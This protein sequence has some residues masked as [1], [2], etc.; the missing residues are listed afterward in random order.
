M[1]AHET[2]I[3][4]ALLIGMAVL[5]ALIVFFIITTL[6]YHRKITASRMERINEDVNTLE[7]ERERVAIDLHDDLGS[8][9]SAIKLDLQGI[10]KSGDAN[11]KELQNI[12]LRID[13][14]ME[15][16]KEVAHE[17]MPRELARKGLGR[18][19]QLLTAR[20]AESSG[21][22]IQYNCSVDHFDTKNSIHIYR[23]AQEVLN[24]AVKHS[25]ATSINFSAWKSK[26]R[27]HLKISDNGI[28]F[29]VKTASRKS[30]GSG[31]HNISARTEL[32]KG[33]I[34][35]TSGINNGTIYEIEVPEK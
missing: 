2:K 7:K 10:G 19:L 6:R 25:K 27:I 3:Y 17:L 13:G 34:Y 12:A 9:L 33:A 30:K 15:R 26:G 20:V 1:D 5:L 35:L 31:L 23:I 11:S 24:N 29:N 21:I 32:M 22:H 16:M 18:A 14:L 28:G 4:Y 8:S